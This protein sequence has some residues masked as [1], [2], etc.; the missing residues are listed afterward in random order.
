M[1]TNWFVATN[2]IGAPYNLAS[3]PFIMVSNLSLQAN[4]VDTNKPMLTITS[5][6]ANQK[7][8]NAIAIIR[9]TATDNWGIS[10]VWYQFNSN[11]WVSAPTTNHWTN[12][13]LTTTL[14][15]GTNMLSAYAE[16][17]GGNYSPTNSVKFTSGSTFQLQ[18]SL[19]GA[20]PLLANGLNFSLQLSTNLSGH[21]QYS[22]NLLTW[23]T[24][25]TFKA[26]NSVLNFRDPAA[27]NSPHRFY[28]ATVP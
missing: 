8:T 4:F 14:V 12:W 19:T 1:F 27:T 2:G 26:T 10:N 13:G 20:S 18:L 5:P 17:W 24:L 7:M 11:G 15:T 22:T 3:L 9:G 6:T 28:R 25:T 16:D 21:I 23:V